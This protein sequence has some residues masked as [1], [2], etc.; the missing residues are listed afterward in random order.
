MRDKI[1]HVVYLMIENR[2]FDHVCGWL[3]GKGEK[4]INFVGRDGPFDGASLEMFN[5]DPGAKGGAQA[6]HLDKYKD[7]RLSEEWNLDFLPE[8]PYHDKTDVMRQFFY[9]QG[10][11]YIERAKPGMGGFVWNN[12]VHEV[13][14][15]YSPD[16]LPVLNGL[17]RA[18]CRVGRVVQLN[19]QRHRPQPRLRLYRISV[20]PAQQFPERH[21][22][23]LLAV[24]AAPPLDLEGAVDQRLRRLENLRPSRLRT[25]GFRG[26]RRAKQ[27]GHH[28]AVHSRRPAVR[29]FEPR[30]HIRRR[31]LDR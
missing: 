27:I 25:F 2:S 31:Q 12:G 11:G 13:M 5:I 22:L 18:V 6:V 4:G 17:G 10:E 30:I 23:R 3:Y 15:T 7:G 26:D 8:D 20:G 29:L 24:H 19:A 21:Q 28:W 9:S 14:T 1:K 16:Q